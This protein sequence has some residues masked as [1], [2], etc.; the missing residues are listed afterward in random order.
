[1][2]FSTIFF[3]LILSSCSS[4]TL[5]KSTID[6]HLSTGF[7]LIYD[8]EDYN[9]KIISGKLNDFELEIGHNK[10]KKNSI[11]KIT[12]PENKKSLEL[13]VSKN[14]EY[15][16]FYKIIIS[17]KVGEKLGLNE[18]IPFVDIQ[19]RIKNKSFIAKKAVTFSEEKKVSDK[20]PVTKVKINNISTTKE[21]KTK[22]TKK[23]S[24]IVDDFYSK[25]SAENLIDTLEHK[26]VKKGSLKVKRVSK[27]K[28]RLS[29][30]PYSSINTLKKRYFELNKYGFEDLDIKQN[31]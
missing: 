7:A 4:G 30:G 28:F 9:N 13:K 2:R 26:Y 31:D 19:Q 14:I 12:N 18:N 16:D 20:A 17:R 15:P 8:E 23:F 27:N 10:L 21:V 29:A 25:E 3:I 22:K 24:I 5:Q 11:I 6:P 1:M